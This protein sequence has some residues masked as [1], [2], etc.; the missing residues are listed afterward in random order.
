MSDD[1]SE[2]GKDKPEETECADDGQ[3]VAPESPLDASAATDP[4]KPSLSPD[5]VK[6]IKDTLWPGDDS[7]Q[8]FSLTGLFC[9]V[10]A[11]AVVLGVGIR[12]PRPVFAGLTGF[13]TLAGMVVLAL[14]NSPP[15]ALRIAWWVLLGTYLLAM[16]LAIWA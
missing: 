10:T 6:W 9:I 11:T 13:A 3:P 7:D 4:A 5:E 2:I 15:F 1:R 14:M 8:R 12:L 16:G